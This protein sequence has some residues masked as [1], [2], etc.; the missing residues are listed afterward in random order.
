[1]ELVYLRVQEYMNIGNTGFNFSHQH[2]IEYI[3]KN[4][5]KYLDDKGVLKSNKLFPENLNITAIVG[6]N[7][8]GKSSLVKLCEEIFYHSKNVKNIIIVYKIQEQLY[9]YSDIK[10]MVVDPIIE[11]TD[12]LM[13]EFISYIA[14]NP[15]PFSSREK[16]HEVNMD[17]LFDTSFRTVTFNTNFIV[18][19]TL[20]LM[21]E[22]ELSSFVF[23]PEK[24]IITDIYIDEIIF[25]LKDNITQVIVAEHLD[26]LSESIKNNEAEIDSLFKLN[27]I[28]FSDLEDDFFN[29]IMEKT[30]KSIDDFML[31]DME[32]ME[33]MEVFNSNFDDGMNHFDFMNYI[34]AFFSLNKKSMPEN[35]DEFYEILKEREFNVSTT[36]EINQEKLLK[37]YRNYFNY[38]FEDTNQRKFH[39]LSH[40]QKSLYG[41]MINLLYKVDL[42]PEK[43][44]LFF[45]DE[46]DLS[47]HPEWQKSFINE[48]INM[49]S[50]RNQN[51]H[52]IFTTHSPFLISD[53]EQKNI[54]FLDKEK[55][56]MCK[57]MDGLSSKKQTFGTNIHTLLSDSF[58]MEKGLMGEFAQRKIEEIFIEYKF[59][60]K[61]ANTFKKGVNNGFEL[62]YLI[63]KIKEFENIQMIIGDVYLANVVQ[64]HID[65][66]K[67]IIYVDNAKEIKINK[68][69]DEIKRLEEL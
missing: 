32:D 27:N 68:L 16:F 8:S 55:D 66:M 65:E 29:L 41:Q 43:S 13:F 48:F 62:N 50:S 42:S 20:K 2:Q 12:E 25:D 23:K 19:A 47:L 51:I 18:R 40:G 59:L 60:L 63:E 4:K 5:I 67:Q 1:M 22:V 26:I 21:D 38:D 54:V 3:E 69:K 37:E 57:I 56:G 36:S 14:E 28:I 52:L 39:H 11:Y 46:P 31:L 49:F 30:Q 35:I 53:L 10:G 24:I 17:E 45:L 7:G 64:N 33:D 9:Y 15:Y 61:N 34:D 44:F 6:K 58:F